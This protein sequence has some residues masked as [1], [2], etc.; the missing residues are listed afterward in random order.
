MSIEHRDGLADPVALHVSGLVASYG[1]ATVV[2]DV[3]FDVAA[4]EF[5]TL[6]G[7]SGCGKSTTLRCV[8]GL[9]PVIDGTIVVGD[10]V[11]S[12]ATTHMRPER[13][14]I[15][16]VFQSYAIWPH[17]SVFDNVGYGITGRDVRT[18]KTARVRE[19]L[20]LVG[21]ADLAD[22]PA[23]GLSGGQQQRVA[24]ARALATRPRVLLL[25]EPLSN[26]DAVLRSRMRAELMRI[27][28]E[29]GTTTLYVTHDRREALSMSH[30]IVVL[31]DG[32][33]EQAGTPRQ[34]Y[35]QPV[36][37]FVAEFLG[38]ANVVPATVTAIDRQRIRATAHELDG[39]PIFELPATPAREGAPA[40]SGDVINLVLRP[41]AIHIAAGQTT[42]IFGARLI[43][44]EYLGSRSEIVVRSG[45]H[46][47]KGELTREAPADLADE[48]SLYAP[49]EAISWVPV[50]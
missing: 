2:N 3:S 1:G 13:R 14:R 7:P 10:E 17:M 24:L 21:L 44:R 5:V 16:M 48:V 23:T 37:R 15:N 45:G 28:R 26:L 30:R 47:L 4:S 18:G 19:L 31:R 41:E 12:S 25:D 27:Q 38:F 43:A 29:T 11:L 36:S 22:R 9:H 46:V 6:L 40:A 33:V 34:L 32:R 50:A 35:D 49:P 8:A 42:N 39:A 20:E